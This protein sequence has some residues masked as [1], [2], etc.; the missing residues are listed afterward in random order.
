MAGTMGDLVFRSQ[1]LVGRGAELAQAQ[2]AFDEAL[3]GHGRTL[4]VGGEAGIGKSRLLD[5]VVSSRCGPQAAHPA[6]RAF[7]G[8]CFEQDRALP[9]GPLIDL[10]RTADL[11]A[12]QR[13]LE[14]SPLARLLP[15]LGAPPPSSEPE[16]E[17]RWLYEALAEVLGIGMLTEARPAVVWIED[18]HWADDASLD[19]LLYA[20]R[21]ISSHPVILA[22]T[23]RSEETGANL[24]RFLASLDRERLA[25]EI[26]LLRLDARE[27]AKLIQSI[28]DLPAAPHPEFVTLIH[29]LTDGNPF[30]VE[31]M[32][33]SLVA[34][35]DVFALANQWGRKPVRQI[36]VPRTVQAAVRAGTTKLE[37]GARR[38]LDIAA[39]VGQRWDFTLLSTLAGV[40]EAALTCHVKALLEAHLVIEESGDTFAFRHALTRQ[41][42]YSAMLARE[43]TALHAATGIALEHLSEQRPGAARLAD[44]AHHFYE[45]GVWPKTVEYAQQAAE[46]A[47]RIGAPRAAAEQWTRAIDA[48]RQMGQPPQPQ[49]LRN[50]G[51]AF[52]TLGQFDAAQADLNDALRAVHGGKDA[53][54]EWRCLLDLGFL[55]TSRDFQ[56]SRDY[57]E[58]AL[59]IARRLGEPATLAHTLNRIGNWHV[60]C[61]QPHAGERLHREALAIFEMLGDQHGI[62]ATLDLL[63]GALFLAADLPGGMACYAQAA[64][65]FR[66]LNDRRGLSSS[67]A[68]LTH[69]G[70]IL[71]SMLVLA[72]ASECVR[73]G[74]AALQL[75]R[76]LDW[77]SGESFA[78]VVL[79]MCRTMLGD[80]GA[81]YSLLSAGTRLARDIDHAQGLIVGTFGL[82]SLF[83]DWRA[84]TEAERILTEG[85]ALAKP[86]NIAFGDRLYIA[87]LA[88]TH[89]ALGHYADA[90]RAL[91]AVIGATVHDITS[92]PTL[93]ER[94]CWLARATAALATGHSSTALDIVDRLIELAPAT[95]APDAITEP[96]LL[97]LRGDALAALQRTTE[98]IVA[99]RQALAAAELQGARP[100]QWQIHAALAALLTRGAERAQAESHLATA[101]QL[102]DEL[103]ARIADESMREQFLRAV[104]AA[105]PNAPAPTRL[106]AAKQ[107]YDGL[108]E[109]ERQV[110]AFVARGLSN[111][112]IALALSVSQRT[113]AA[114][115]GNILAKLH[116]G[117]R[118]QIASWATARGL[119]SGD[120]SPPSR[121]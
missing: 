108:T 41:A 57:F 42:I 9:F 106:R 15:E 52:E 92:R 33:K 18:A 79:G 97:K 105:M 66:A 17:R 65:R 40:D 21:R 121:G 88:Q 109:R 70:T 69:R 45:A 36:Q 75:A 113:A 62:A 47:Q 27:T 87:M 112:E 61:E 115:I 48:A 89:T 5:A 14:F 49:M 94:L 37:P 29:T 64:E 71:N 43:R 120:D 102:A 50:R 30:F 54:T 99:L 12:S 111:R 114:H 117:T 3:N 110:A 7:K 77:R 90:K 86:V 44:L 60:N 78:M 116:F 101:R 100:L 28:F 16:Q 67:L 11:A 76:E 63:A 93:A 58:R 25:R 19:F 95:A 22:I 82:G 38:V 34:S 119:A 68:W 118:A 1:R 80:Y 46:H 98:A 24:E 107:A 39:V 6:L 85:L 81:A 103:A 23:Y 2:R 53:K 20:A 8:R 72:H 55:Y 56:V 26:V 74:E 84:L 13:M 32:L 31:E 4:L 51:M 10:L 83:F 91:D 59:D 96:H 104:L 35:G 73:N